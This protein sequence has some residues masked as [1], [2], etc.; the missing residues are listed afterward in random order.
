[1]YRRVDDF[2]EQYQNLAEGTARILGALTEASL[3]QEVAEGHRTIRRLAWHIVIT[4]PEMMNRTG[5]GLSSVDQHTPPPETADSIREAYDAVSSELVDAV[6]ANW[7]DA[8]LAETDDMYGQT[9]ARGAS[10]HALILHEVHHRAQLT[11]LMRQAGLQVPGVFG[12]AKEEWGQY[13]MEAP[14][15]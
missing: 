9:W 6:T 11:V 2:L 13:G 15:V 7:S 3:D 12:P 14:P 1:M 5:L 10:A 8:T 4:V